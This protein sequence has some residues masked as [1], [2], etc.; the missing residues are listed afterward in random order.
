MVT[1]LSR[2]RA[3]RES[4]G[5]RTYFGA[6]SASGPHG[7][8]STRLPKAKAR[9][10]LAMEIP[11]RGINSRPVGP[12]YGPYGT[13]IRRM[14]GRKRYVHVRGGGWLGIQALREEAPGHEGFPMNTPF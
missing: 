9:T 7:T 12:L 4:C 10:R 3:G 2:G 14:G 1:R 5:H 6:V 11:P 8:K 13:Q